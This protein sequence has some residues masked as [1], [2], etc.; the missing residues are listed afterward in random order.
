MTARALAA[1]AFVSLVPFAT[2]AGCGYDGPFGDAGMTGPAPAPTL[3]SLQAT[4]FTPRCAVPG[5][6]LQPG[7]AL[8]MDLSEGMTWGNVVDVRS[9][10]V[11]AFVRVA[12]GD[13]S[14]SY[15][16]LKVTGDPRILGERMPFGGPPLPAG[17][18]E[19]LAEW[20]LAGARND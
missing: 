10:E 2:L 7:A 19:S 4:I 6:H 11:P 9:V 15:L 3:S 18:I 12:P 16:Y 14:N 8:G 13:P 5:C 17:D 1:R 20:I